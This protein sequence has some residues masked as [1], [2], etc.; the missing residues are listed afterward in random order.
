MLITNCNHHEE[1]HHKY[2]NAYREVEAESLF[3]IFPWVI[4]KLLKTPSHR[5]TGK[6]ANQ[7]LQWCFSLNYIFAKKTKEE[8]SRE[9]KF[10]KQK[11]M[12]LNLRELWEQ[13]V[14]T[15]FPADTYS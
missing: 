5:R 3:H 7:M 1:Q 14:Q 8:K 9:F 2:R 11:A 10:R 12:H 13:T 4:Q 15:P 6:E